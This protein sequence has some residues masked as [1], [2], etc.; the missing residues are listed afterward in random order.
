[1]KSLGVALGLSRAFAVPDA[2]SSGLG[3]RSKPVVGA[4]PEIL[5]CFVHELKLS[6]K[7]R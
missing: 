2:V 1:M 7:Y 6:L 3:L 4:S 5:Y